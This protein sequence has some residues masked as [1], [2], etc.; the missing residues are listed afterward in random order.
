[1]LEEGSRDSLFDFSAE[2]TGVIVSVT[3]EIFNQLF[4]ISW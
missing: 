3:A 4:L 1:M 2:S